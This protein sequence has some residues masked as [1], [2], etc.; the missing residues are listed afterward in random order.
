MAVSIL[1]SIERRDTKLYIGDKYEGIMYS[2]QTWELKEGLQQ[3]PFP[4][5]TIC[6]KDSLG[7]IGL[8]IFVVNIETECANL[9]WRGRNLHKVHT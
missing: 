3:N 4:L 1:V 2:V 9:V 8:I 6:D 7:I 5:V